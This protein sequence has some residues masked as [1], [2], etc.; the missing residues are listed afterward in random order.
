[1]TF[2]Y[3]IYQHPFYSGFGLVILVVWLVFWKGLALWFASKNNQRGWF[4]AL[5]ILNT[6]G[7]LPIIYLIWF[8]PVEKS[9]GKETILIETPKEASIK[10][11]ESIKKSLKIPSKKKSSEK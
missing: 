9:N 10:S 4:I 11:K 7:L 6:L 8:K 5:L 2:L 1:M 3:N